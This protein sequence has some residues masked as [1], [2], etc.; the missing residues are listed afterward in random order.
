MTRP[1]SPE[2]G[3]DCPSP[4]RTHI[5]ALASRPPATPVTTNE[6]TGCN[7]T[8][9]RFVVSTLYLLPLLLLLPDADF[10]KLSHRLP[11]KREHRVAGRAHAHQHVLHTQAGARNPHRPMGVFGGDQIAAVRADRGHGVSGFPRCFH[12]SSE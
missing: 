6:K 7:C 2:P 5:N 12:D 11:R 9:S 8:R 10:A 1:T 4:E 3:L